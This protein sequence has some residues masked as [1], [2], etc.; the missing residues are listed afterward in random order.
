MSQHVRSVVTFRVAL[1]EIL[2]LIF[3]SISFPTGTD[4]G[5]IKQPRIALV[6]ANTD[7]GQPMGAL[8]NPKIDS[9]KVSAALESLG[10][11]VSQQE[12]LTQEQMKL[13]IRRFK[14]K[15]A[16]AGNGVVGFFYYAGHGGADKVHQDNYLLPVDAVSANPSSPSAR[17]VSMK[18]IKSELETVR[19]PTAIVIVIDACRTLAANTNMDSSVRSAA[20]IDSDPS[21]EI[22]QSEP[23]LGFLVGYSTSQGRTAADDSPYAEALSKRLLEPGLTLPQVFEKVRYDVSSISRQIPYEESKIDKPLCFTRCETDTA[24]AY[25]KNSDLYVAKRKEVEDALARIVALQGDKRCKPAWE[26]LMRLRDSAIVHEKSKNFNTA[27][28][29]YEEIGNQLVPI[30]SYLTTVDRLA[31]MSGQMQALQEKNRTA[32]SERAAANLKFNYTS[33]YKG[34]FKSL[35]ANL[36]R[37]QQV[38]KVPIDFAPLRK[39]EDQMEAFAQTGDYLNAI[40]R[41]IEGYNLS[42]K[43]FEATTGSYLV[44]PMPKEDRIAAFKKANQVELPELDSTSMAMIDNSPAG[45]ACK[46]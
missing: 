38:K 18:W 16:Q 34:N 40:E 4:A 20:S 7:Y 41:A 14:E 30:E 35:L 29:T 3:A 15:L 22:V 19:D 1:V 31:L 37:L 26:R 21:A 23:A 10:F 36:V 42:I 13:A 27:G 32:R 24:G 5:E 2:I 25:E 12:D 44:E 17:T 46:Q 45:I 33:I 11:S 43:T 8:R 28:K 6:I 9:R 39:I